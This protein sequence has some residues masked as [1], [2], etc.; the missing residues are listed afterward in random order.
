MCS[1]DLWVPST[2]CS[3]TVCPYSRFDSSASSTFKN[4]NQP[5][6]LTYG[7]GSVNGTYATDTVTI[8]GATISNQQ[9]GLA[10]STADILTTTT[11]SGF[12]VAD[13]NLTSLAT[14]TSDRVI[15]DGILGLG[16]P[17][18]TAAAS[19]NQGAYNPFAFNLAIQGVISDPIFSIYLNSA[20]STGWVGEIVF[21]GVD[22]TKYQGN[23]TYLNVLSLTSST[24]PIKKRAL[25]DN[26]NKYYWMVGAQ[27]FAVTDPSN[28]ANALNVTFSSVGGYVFDTGTTLTY[29]PTNM[30]QQVI[31]HVAGSN[32]AYDSN[33]GGF[34]VDCSLTSSTK[35][36]ELIMTNSQTG[37]GEPVVLSIPVSALVI[38][39]DSNYCLFGIAPSSTSLGNNIYL[40][41]ESVLRNAYLV[42]DMGNTRLGLA[43]A[44][45]VQG[46]VQGVSA[47]A[48]STSAGSSIIYTASYYNYL[49][50]LIGS[51]FVI[52]VL[53]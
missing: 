29:L 20:S 36:F 12:S 32:Y 51:F 8:A 15:A 6:T 1:A 22:S 3:A 2:S 42:F 4:L 14:T 38:P 11:S 5:F 47:S 27:G 13:T 46:S 43:A 37:S 31:E 25:A 50:T 41:G 21:G 23:I 49:F 16:F 19:T 48:S 53:L 34:V 10:S 52:S 45:G 33:S 40:I 24:T 17:K 7:V 39:L 30:A 28:N 44:V 9:F 18:L 26:S 35:Q